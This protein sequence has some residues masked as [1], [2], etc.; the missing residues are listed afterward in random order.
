MAGLRL[1]IYLDYNATTPVD[2]E[3]AEAMRPYFTEHF[4]NPSSAHAYGQ[5][6]RDS[7]DWVRTQ[8]AASL[9]C[10]ADEVVFTGGGSESNN[11]AIKGIAFAN[12]ERGRHIITSSV[13]HPAVLATCQYLEARHGFAVTY[14]PVGRAGRVDP[15]DVER[16][17]RPDT[18]LITI[19]A[20]NNETG[21]LQPVAEIGALARRAG[22]AMHTDAAQVVGKA[23]VDVEALQVDLLTVVGHKLY[24]PK[25]IGALYVRRGVRLDS[26]VHGAGHEGGRRAGTENVPYIVGLGKACA[27]ARARCTEEPARLAALRDRLYAALQSR[28][29]EM[30]LNGHPQLRL[31]NALNVSFP[32]VA[33]YELLETAREVAASTGS[34]CHAGTPEP[35]PVLKAMGMSD[36]VAV[37]AVRLSLG[38]W[39]TPEE[40][41]LAADMLAAAAVRLRERGHREEVR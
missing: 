40:V 8:V 24:A 27:I 35:S 39:T 16:A 29:G 15:D 18:I 32:G 19:M 36:D 34:A 4:G 1:P 33:G 28:L 25:G 17:I 7:V 38:R 2:P 23:P 10:S 30:P 6:A 22:I 41:D 13:E 9:G 37:G 21:T 3:V 12:R 31:P 11:L 5:Q 20:A 26:L 14:L